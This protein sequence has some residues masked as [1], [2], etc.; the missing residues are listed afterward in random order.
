[1]KND[2]K[3]I[4]SLT[5]LQS[6]I[7]HSKLKDSES[8][9]YH[10]QTE[11]TV[12]L[13][14]SGEQIKE[15]L[16]LL[17]CQYEVLKTAFVLPESTGVPKQ[18]ILTEREIP[19]DVLT[20]ET[21]TLSLEIEQYKEKDLKRGFDLQKDSLI[22][23]AAVLRE[24][25]THL[26]ISVHHIIIDGWSFN[27]L[28]N[29]FVNLLYQVH[30]GTGME[31]IKEAI[32]Q[33]MDAVP[34]FDE[35]IRFLKTYDKEKAYRFWKE[36]LSDI[37][38]DS[39][40]KSVSDKEV[41]TGKSEVLT[42]RISRELTKKL[43]E[44]AASEGFTINT[45]SE[46]AWGILLQ[47]YACSAD[48]VFAR[49]LSGRE[50][51]LVN[52]DKIFGILIRSVPCRVTCT[53]EETMTSLCGKLY[54]NDLQAMEYS[55]VSLS[56]MQE[57]CGFSTE[58]IHSV[59]A[60]EN[61]M[62]I[63]D[64]NRKGVE[65]KSTREETSYP[66]SVTYFIEN[67]QLCFH[68]IFDGKVYSLSEMNIL[69]DVLCN[70]LT[71][72]AKHPD[73]KVSEIE[74]IDACSR[75]IIEGVHRKEEI[76]RS[77]TIIHLL[78]KQV[79]SHP[80]KTAIECYGKR[81]TYGGLWEMASKV[82]GELRERG[83]TRNRCVVVCAEKCI[84]VVV[85]MYGILMAGGTC[86]VISDDYP[87]RRQEY[88]WKATDALVALYHTRE[89]KIDVPSQCIDDAFF[90]GAQMDL[91]GGVKSENAA[92]IIFT[93]GTTGNPK[94]VCLTH[95]NFLS[96]IMCNAVHDLQLGENTVFMHV[97]AQTF[98][99][100]LLEIHGCLLNGGKL[101][102]VEKEDIIDSEKAKE[103]I[104][105]QKIN[106]MFLSTALFHQA[107]ETD[108]SVFDGVRT[109]SFGGERC[110]LNA[111][112]KVFEHNTKIRLVN[113]YGPTE[114]SIY[115]TREIY[116]RPQKKVTI[117]FP[118]SNTAIHILNGNC[119]CSIGMAGELCVCGGQVAD[120]Y[121]REEKN[122]KFVDSPFDD[123]RMY[124]TGDFARWNL[125]GSIAYIGR[126]DNQIKL[127]GYRIE[128]N[129]IEAAIQQVKGVTASAVK[130]FQQSDNDGILVGYF[131]ADQE[132]NEYR[133]LEELKKTLPS[134]SIPK[135]L[136]QVESFELNKNGKID[137]A[138]LQKPQRTVNGTHKM[139]E[140][141]VQ[142]N[143]CASVEKVLETTN[144]SIEDDLFELGLDSLKSMKLLPELKKYGYQFAISDL[145]SY[146][147]IEKL[148]QNIMIRREIDAADSKQTM[149]FKS[150]EEVREYL[151]EAT[152]Q[153]E[154]ALIN[155]RDIKAEELLANQTR[156]SGMATI[157][158]GIVIPFEQEFNIDILTQSVLHL[159][160]TQ[161]ALR[162]TFRNNLLVYKAKYRSITL[163]YLNLKDAP[164]SLRDEVREYLST[165]YFVKHKAEKNREQALHR[166][167]A[168]K[169]SE[170]DC[171]LYMPVDHM[172]FDAVSGEIVSR[173][174]M[175]YYYNP[176]E[177][178]GDILSYSDYAAQLSL[179]P[180]NVKK[181]E[182]AEM[183]NLKEFS[184]ALCEYGALD[185]SNL[186]NYVINLK[187]GRDVSFFSEEQL[188][189]YAYKLFLEMVTFSV[190]VER[191][192]FVTICINREY[193]K[194]RF[195]DTVGLFVDSLPIVD[196]KEAK[197]NYQAVRDKIKWLSEHNI[198]AIST[199]SGK[200]LVK[201]PGIISVMLSAVKYIDK[202]PVF[203][204]LGLYT[205][206]NESENGLRIEELLREETKVIRTVDVKVLKDSFSFLVFCREGRQEE[207][208]NHLQEYLTDMMQKDR[209]QYQEVN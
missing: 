173:E 129:E 185:D 139:P 50:I 5:G 83:I 167:V 49:I 184:S 18:V 123:G 102:I 61:Y 182:L 47:K 60:F 163:P 208:Q 192:P 161:M 151:K 189:N 20:L 64:A 95:A 21:E 156:V 16:T 160:N 32:A 2:I 11:M 35:Y 4:Y 72:Y 113:I 28:L 12:A 115:V 130:L 203:N 183:L 53:E 34:T 117:G 98:D 165:E 38:S 206:M 143:I 13:G 3:K 111:V 202:L 187:L 198:S 40:I 76:D 174:I 125:D 106:T 124:R 65:I 19:L 177:E 201:N 119:E 55:S 193:C 14:L 207:L 87:V 200:N 164:E 39:D 204:Y 140:N 37:Y 8:S 126:V 180:Q 147:S 23:V 144:V 42:G 73:C 131:T 150:M 52:A 205:S 96:T 108:P 78:K 197:L 45:V 22:R 154:D 26:V 190:D 84:E 100:S 25:E 59:V 194:K 54:R 114:T 133:V 162:T 17:G 176:Q 116:E 36:Y 30:Q 134:Y 29:A 75:K 196:T 137:K 9:S 141:D 159:L 209:I 128:L 48:A 79:D 57:Y 89:L 148:S 67:G 158:S 171:R 92:H 80:E 90:A 85:S 149:K 112:N 179:G 44:S 138:K 74:F 166:A 146:R 51:Q 86:T 195:Y 77:E 145:Y 70:I 120:G 105:D 27:L 103:I 153:Y 81:I 186:K 172:I 43:S 15:A 66:V 107:A 10:L 62:S 24:K 168:V 135:Q 31:Q 127:H 91:P 58:R 188:W 68:I 7:F 69:K 82:A 118:N 41:R 136:H 122:G 71:Y 132:L 121:I 99:A 155:R 88:I 94:G 199:I 170:N 157:M 104:R 93:S 178:D 56:E 181:H 142:K 46:A 6:G 101:V 110:S 33:E 169:Y 97:S 191:I 1:M 175:R 152:K 63:D 109:V